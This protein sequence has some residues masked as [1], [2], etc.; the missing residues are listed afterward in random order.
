MWIT[1]SINI[2]HIEVLPIPAYDCFPYLICSTRTGDMQENHQSTSLP[3]K[4]HFSNK[5]FNRAN[6]SLKRC[7]VTVCLGSKN[8][9]KEFVLNATICKIDC[10]NRYCFRLNGDTEKILTLR[11][12]AYENFVNLVRILAPTLTATS[13]AK[14]QF[15]A[16]LDS[17]VKCILTYEHIYLLGDVNARLD[18]KSWS[19]RV[20]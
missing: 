4:I 9:N 5:L 11:L 8:R 1:G 19:K 13:K 6:C 3:P 15:Y 16:H 18:G 12:T 17:V 2:E 14:R 20:M 7:T 10:Y